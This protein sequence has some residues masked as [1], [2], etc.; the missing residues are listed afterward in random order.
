MAPCKVYH[1]H[2]EAVLSMRACTVGSVGLF[3]PWNTTVVACYDRFMLLLS[4]NV[5]VL[6]ACIS[7]YSM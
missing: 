4:W 7:C 3:W 6:A 1:V 5:A 2:R